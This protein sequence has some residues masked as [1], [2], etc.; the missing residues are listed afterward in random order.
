M[1]RLLI[2]SVFIL[3]TPSFGLLPTLYQAHE[4]C[5]SGCATNY[6]GVASNLDGCKKGCDYKLYNQNCPEECSKLSMDDQVRASC[7]V[8]CSLMSDI[9][10]KELEGPLASE[11]PR[12]I[13]LIRLRQRPTFELPSLD[14]IFDKHPADMFNQIIQQWKADAENLFQNNDLGKSPE[15]KSVVHLFKA[16]P[17]IQSGQNARLDSSSESSE[18]KLTKIIKDSIF[19]QEPEKESIKGRVQ[20]WAQDV[21]GKWNH[22]VKK[23][24]PMPIWILLAF[25]LCLSAFFWYMIVSLCSHAPNHR[26]LSVQA[27]ELLLDNTDEKEKFSVYQTQDALPIKMKISNI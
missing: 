27:Q 22:L 18:E 10:A 13:I 9:P 23:Q 6:A 2:L 24:A 11:R 4:R 16:I 14:N 20:Q 15:L 17:L 3:S 19:P 26:H 7:V 12:S 25:F 1:F 8:G 5:Y 21:R